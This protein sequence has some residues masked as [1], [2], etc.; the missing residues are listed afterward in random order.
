[1]YYWRHFGVAITNPS[2]SVHIGSIYYRAYN[3]WSLAQTEQFI[4]GLAITAGT[5]LLR[6]GAEG[7]N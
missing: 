1:M 6:T 4:A 5:E 2:C 7:P 3:F